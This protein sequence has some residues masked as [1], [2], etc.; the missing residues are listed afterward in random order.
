MDT[1]VTERKKQKKEIQPHFLQEL[2][3]RCRGNAVRIKE[4]LKEEYDVDIGY[5][6]LKTAIRKAELRQNIQRVGEYCFSP[7]EEMQHDTSPHWVILDGKKTKAQCA[8]LILG[9]SRKL[10]IQYYLHIPIQFG[11]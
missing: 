6:T 1:P 4:V 2:F 9:Y 7:G 3:T 10:F 8:S 5:T 11:R